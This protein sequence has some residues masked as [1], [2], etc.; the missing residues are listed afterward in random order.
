MRSHI[1]RDR[2]QVTI[3]LAD[4]VRSVDVMR[5]LDTV[6]IDVIDMNR[7]GSTLDD[8]FLALTGDAPAPSAPE[9]ISV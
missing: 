7:R 8:V 1:E 4:G 2:L 3:P 6:G 5:A 9:E